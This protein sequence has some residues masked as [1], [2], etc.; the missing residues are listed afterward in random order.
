MPQVALA[1]LRQSNGTS[2]PD[3]WSAEGIST[4]DNLAS[5]DLE[6]SAEPLKSLNGASRIEPVFPESIYQK[7]M[8]RA[9]MYGGTWDRLLL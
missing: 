5:L 2:N 8:V 1:W 3:H 9:T 6:L 7:E 4:P